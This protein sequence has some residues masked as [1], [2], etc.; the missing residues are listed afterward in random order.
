M[1]DVPVR[2]AAPPVISTVG[3]LRVDSVPP[4]SSTRVQGPRTTL[5][6]TVR[7]AVLIALP[8]LV[9][10]VGRATTS[11]DHKPTVARSYVNEFVS[12]HN[13]RVEPKIVGTPS[14]DAL[15]D[16]DSEPTTLDAQ[17]ARLFDRMS[18][19][20]GLSDEQ[21]QRVQA[22][23]DASP[24]LGQGNPALSRHPITRSDCHRIRREANVTRANA[25][26]CKAFGMVAVFDPSS[27]QTEGDARLCMDEL[28]FPN[29]PCEYPVVHV[30]AREA[31][32]LCAAVGKRICDAHEWEGACAGAL[33]SADVEYQWGHPRAEVQTYHNHVRDVVWSYGPKNDHAA[34]GLQSHRSPDCPGGGY[35]K[36]GSNTYPTGAFPRCRSAFGA[37]DM[38][39]NV[40]EH[41]NLPT[42]P[43][44]LARNGGIGFTEMKGSWFAFGK[45]YPHA[46]DCRWRAPAWHETRLSSES[47][48]YN[49]HLGFRCC[50]DI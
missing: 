6:R 42:V 28:E 22:I 36:C 35:E 25:P 40:A 30:R 34:C 2:D 20:L 19:D 13:I 24:H 31:A 17:R 8:S 43:S 5:R 33:R 48:H 15:R 1:D 49:Y 41:M 26:T 45:Q 38:H 21:L 32:A 44:E 29:I 4:L 3:A 23:F 14:F 11:L 27:G 18:A 16:D 46:D 47:S 37:F 9:A 39:G 10:I 12:T 7:R 50:K